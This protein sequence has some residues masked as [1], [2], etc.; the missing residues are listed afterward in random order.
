MFNERAHAEDGGYLKEWDVEGGPLLSSRRH[1]QVLASGK[2]DWSAK[3]VFDDFLKG[4]AN[5][6]GTLY[7][8]QRHGGLLQASMTSGIKVYPPS[9]GLNFLMPH[10]VA[11]I[12]PSRDR[13]VHST[14][15]HQEESSH[16]WWPLVFSIAVK[17]KW[18]WTR[19]LVELTFNASSY[20]Y[21]PAGAHH[22]SA[23][24]G[25]E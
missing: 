2:V 8:K 14:S 24:S 7:S 20:R 22:G 4:I 23:P 21:R 18:E 19:H 10:A 25:E 1:W 13:P 5:I 12:P 17:V 3:S 15:A 16:N 9:S 11:G 6:N